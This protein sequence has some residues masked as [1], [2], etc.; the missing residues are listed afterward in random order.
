MGGCCSPTCS[1]ATRRRR[2]RRSSSSV[3]LRLQVA[4]CRFAPAQPLAHELVCRS[5]VP[6]YRFTGYR[7][8]HIHNERR[9]VNHACKLGG[10]Q[11]QSR[12]LR[13]RAHRRR[14]AIII[15]GPYP[16]RRKAADIR[17]PRPG[18]QVGN[19]LVRSVDQ[20]CL[21]VWSGRPSR[22]GTSTPLAVVFLGATPVG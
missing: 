14:Q 22:S 1:A 12:F 18:M 13:K 19:P 7:F 17:I 5:Q 15:A 20:P 6:G 16:S 10:R 3:D 21:P 4:G 11:T 8:L 2:S 9:E